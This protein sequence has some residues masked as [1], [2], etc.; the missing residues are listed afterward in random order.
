MTSGH[1]SASVFS[2]KYECVCVHACV[3]VCVRTC[4]CAWV[5]TS[6]SVYAYIEKVVI[7]IEKNEM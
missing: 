5:R 1:K 7:K 2:V 4:V 3:Q 6:L